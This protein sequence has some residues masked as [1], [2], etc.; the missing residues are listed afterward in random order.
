M[1]ADCS[2]AAID[3]VSSKPRD[4]SGDLHAPSAISGGS[5]KI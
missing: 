2:G 4:D 5:R 1:Y 3:G